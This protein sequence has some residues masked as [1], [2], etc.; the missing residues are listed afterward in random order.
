[1]RRVLTG[2]AIS[3]GS[4]AGLVVGIVVALLVLGRVKTGEA[5]DIVVQ[6]PV[7]PSDRASLAR[8]RH[9]AEAIALCTEC[10]QNGLRGGI[11]SLN[12]GP[13]FNFAPVPPLVATVV[14]PNLT[15]GRGG[16]GGDY[17]AADWDR[18]IRHGVARDGRKLVL[19][20]SE[21]YAEMTDSDFG[22]LVSFLRTLPPVDNELPSSGVGVLGRALVGAGQLP[23]AA[24][25][26]RHEEVGQH[27]AVPD[28]SQE[29]GAYLATLANCRACHGSE[30]RGTTGGLGPPPA[31]SLVD[32]TRDWSAADFRKTIR[33]GRTPRG[34]ALDPQKM[35][36]P[37]LANLTDDE[38]NAVFEYLRSISP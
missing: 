25:I 23:L 2:I 24:D 4:V 29:Y 33:N 6:P 11:L 10:H 14:A 1:M 13:I 19:M 17:T 34:R 16:V 28:V 9:I 5:L 30:L 32:S 22:A 27:T 26:V 18:A 15:S 35:P 38:L 21:S 7:I 37:R 8:G 36:W 12:G 20:P 31:P 3:L